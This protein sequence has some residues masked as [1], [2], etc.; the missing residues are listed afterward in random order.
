M[1][2]RTGRKGKPDVRNCKTPSW[3]DGGA[4]ICRGNKGTDGA[5]INA[6][7]K[8]RVWA[9][10]RINLR[11]ETTT[12]GTRSE[13]GLLKEK[14]IHWTRL[15]GIFNAMERP[16]GKSS[17]RRNQVW[18]HLGG[19]HAGALQ[20]ERKEREGTLKGSER[21]ASNSAAARRWEAESVLR[22]FHTYAFTLRAAEKRGG[23]GASVSKGTGQQKRNADKTNSR[24]E[25]AD[26]IR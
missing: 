6:D 10:Q 4:A 13:G 18:E 19:G 25:T 15:P 5:S 16:T 11:L 22:V 1:Q 7:R 2:C 8:R 26:R 14:S 20:S 21:V 3:V 24:R 23:K 9:K 12:L 17:P